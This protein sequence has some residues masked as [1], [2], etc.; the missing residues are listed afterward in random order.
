MRLLHYR[1][2]RGQFRGAIFS[3]WPIA[4]IS[5]WM[6]FRRKIFWGLY[7]LGLLIFFM[8][9]FGQYLLAWAETQAAEDTVRVGVVRAE[10]GKLI[11]VLR[12][13]LRLNGTAYTYRNFFWY[14]GYMVMIILALAGSIVVGNDFQ[15]GSLPF[16]LSKPVSRW[17]YL[18]G[19]CMAVGVFVNLMTTVPAL[20]LYVQF[21]LLDSWSYFAENFRLLLGI[22]G[23]G[24]VLTIC[25]SLFLVATATWLRRTVPMIM[26]WTTLFFFFPLLGRALVSGFRYPA[27]WQLIDLWND[28]YLIGNAMLGLGPDTIRQPH[29][30]VL[31]AALVLGVLSL[32][33]LI[34]LN[35]RIRAVE[36]VR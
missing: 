8:F 12:E 30:V 16:Y 10:P 2:W 29:P 21:G 3:I 27:R 15:F 28:A 20:V 31:E 25:L 26:T 5:L 6:I 24:V 23:Y 13:V 34:Y 11:Q 9:F 17:H 18:I 7:A 19:K 36:I 14:Q 1:S 22:I 4:R 32:L 35:L 33:C